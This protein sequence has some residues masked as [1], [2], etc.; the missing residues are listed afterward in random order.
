[1][2]AG[3]IRDAT[4]IGRDPRPFRRNEPD[5]N[6]NCITQ[7]SWLEHY[8]IQSQAIQNAF[9]DLNA[10]VA[11]GL[12]PCPVT[13]CPFMPLVTAS[14]FAQVRGHLRRAHPQLEGHAD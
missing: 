8:T 13:S 7:F 6:S 14:A 5:L 3:N 9:T 12:I 2:C 10:D 11:A 4:N 1:M